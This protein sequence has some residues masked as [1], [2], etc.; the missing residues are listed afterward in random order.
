[1]TTPYRNTG[2][3]VVSSQIDVQWDAQTTSSDNG[4]TPITSYFLEWDAG[5][6]GV[7]WTEI[8]GSTPASLLTAY[9]VT[10][11]SS[12]LTVGASYGFR[13]T[14]RNKHGWGPVSDP[15]YL[16]AA[17]K[18]STVSAVETFIDST[19]GGIRVQWGAPSANGGTISRYTI[20]IKKYGT[21]DWL[22]S[23]SCDGTSSTIISALTCVIPM[24]EITGTL[25]YDFD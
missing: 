7:T 8:V 16:K 9:S 13:V 2:T 12:G 6:N 18:P 17:Q 4:Y 15:V 22:T 1:M 14:S 24:S 20:E 23:T 5:S 19:T 11:G 21:T 25:A 10:G 3:T